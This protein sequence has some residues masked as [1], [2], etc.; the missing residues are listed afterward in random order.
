MKL[1]ASPGACSLSP[2]IILRELDM[3]FDLVRVGKDKQTSDGHDF[4]AINPKLYVPAL[5]LDD[6]SILTE[7]PAIVQYLADKKPEAK[8]VPAWGTLER[9]RAMEWLNFLSTEVHKSMSPFFNPTTT[10][11]AKEALRAKIAGRLD[12][13]NA[14]LKT[15]DYLLGAAFQVPDAYLFT[16]LTWMPA[17][18]MDRAKWPELERF[19]DRVRQRPTVKA[20]ME[21]EAEMRRAAAPPKDKA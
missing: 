19:F 3:K 13:T 11:E 16:L 20:A 8:L 7:G 9:Y 6:G 21:A 1:Y 2:H 18:S 12:F 17:L 15:Q 4:K 5:E 10:E 14:H